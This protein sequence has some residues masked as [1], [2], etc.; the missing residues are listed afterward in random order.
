MWLS[1]LICGM[2]G[3]NEFVLR[4][5]CRAKLW[6]V[7]DQFAGGEV[8]H[9]AEILLRLDNGVEIAAIGDVDN[10]LAKSLDLGGKT[11]GMQEGRHIGQPHLLDEAPVLAVDDV[12]LA[13]RRLDRQLPGLR[14][15]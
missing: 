5:Q 7:T 4:I 15:G 9:V 11:F 8:G 14:V 12:D 2:F 10:D 13:R 1:P 3:M 6:R